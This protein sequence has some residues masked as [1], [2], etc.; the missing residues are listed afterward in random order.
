MSDMLSEAL[1]YARRKWY[2]FPCREKPG[3]GFTRNGEFITPTEKQPYVTKGLNDATID[4]DQIKAWWTKWPNA[5]IG[6]NA[7]L[8]GLF[9]VDIDRKHVNGLDTFTTWNIN[10]S[11][12]LHSITP[13]GGM[14]IIFTGCGKT[15]SNAKTGIDA[16]GEGGYFIAP[17]SKIIQGENVGEYKRFDDWGRVP[18]VIPDG[19]LA[20]MFPD[21]TSE[22]AKGNFVPQN[23]EKKQLSRATLTFLANGASVGERNST[24]FKILADFAGCEYTR[25]H[26]KEAVLPTCLRIGMTGSEFAQVLEHAFSKPRTSSIPDSIQEKIME[27]GKHVASK[28][29]PEE[30]IV[31]EEA[32]LACLMIDNALIP[33]ISDMLGFEDFQGFKNR[34]IYKAIIRLYNSDMTADYF[35]VSSAV[36]RETS[37]VDLKNI[38]EMINLFAIDTGNANNYADI[39]KEKAG[40]RKIE[41]ILDNKQKYMVSTSLVEMLN[42]IE[43]DVTEVALTSGVKSANVLSS[44]QATQMTIEHTRQMISGEIVQLKTGF[45]SYDYHVGG[46]YSHELVM[47][48]GYAGD[49]KS[50]MA[51]SIINTVAL[52]QNKPVGFFS[53]EMTTRQS[54][55]RLVCQLTG[56]QFKN[57]YQG[58]MNKDEWVKYTEAM[59]RI[60]ASKIYFDDS[61]GMTVP[62]IRSKI[63]KLMEKDIKLIVIDQLEQVRG[64][65]GQP[66]HIRFNKIGY[67]IKNFTKEFDV[68]VLLNH[69]LNRGIMDRKL[70]N[71]EPRLSDLSQA[72]EKPCDQVW[73]ISHLKDD[74]D[75]ILKSKI[76]ILK[77]RNGPKLAFPVIF[78]GE[79]MLFSNPGEDDDKEPFYG[80]RDEEDNDRAGAEPEWAT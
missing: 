55:C 62:E 29:T 1:D 63:R 28:I 51:L 3:E 70:K 58:K 21:K 17:P 12:G 2:V 68:P 4:E 25:E 24:L 73:A 79:R 22:Y 35:T 34:I 26:T 76:K 10:D 66:D 6:V 14:H 65:E 78:V 46:L 61:F 31:I 60:S 49:G 80:G 27:G 71:P 40:I 32:L 45:S 36:D 11:A 38:S 9:V 7:G 23:G 72:G 5:M 54:I 39:I 56:L 69:Q 64:Y 13:S 48:A 52:T 67:D 41:A 74:K 42:S 18:G 50:A 77:N 43:K 47:C 8:S 33:S 19:L 15:S 75:N 53:L 20:N 59:N 16:R 44:E 57:V 30:Q 37:R